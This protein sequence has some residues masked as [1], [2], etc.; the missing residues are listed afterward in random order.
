MLI[1]SLPTLI[2]GSNRT[3]FTGIVNDQLAAFFEL[4]HDQPQAH[5]A[6]LYS[7]YMDPTHRGKGYASRLVS[8]ALEAAQTQGKTAVVRSP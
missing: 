3:K 4:D 5:V 8:A 6:T 2:D 1:L 7:L